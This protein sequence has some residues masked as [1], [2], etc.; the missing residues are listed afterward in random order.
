MAEGGLG[1][2]GLADYV[3]AFSMK[4]WWHFRLR[5]SLWSEFLHGRYC[6]ALHPTL[7]PYNRNH[8]P[9]WHRLCPIRDVAEL[10]IFW[11]LGNGEVSFWHDNWFGEKIL[12]Q[13]VHRE[14]YTMEPVRYYW[15]EGEWMFLRFLGQFRH[16][17]HRLFAKSRLQ[18]VRMTRLYGQ[19]PVMG[20]SRREQPGRLSGWFPP[21][22]SF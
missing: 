10:F 12:A 21:G 19:G 1:V 5:S 18:Q 17:L 8:S 14:S 6:R 16:T 4:L 22:D 20:F 3:R 15:H 9:V 2:R 13:L 11:V 7:V